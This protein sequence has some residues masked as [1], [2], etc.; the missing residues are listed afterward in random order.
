MRVFSR[1]RPLLDLLTD[2]RQFLRSLTVL[3]LA[4]KRPS[5]LRGDKIKVREKNSNERRWFEGVVT[6]VELSRVLL[7]FAK[8]F[9]PSA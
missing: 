6:V 5:V 4:E 2:H 1:H 7:K 3:G 8:S 9:K